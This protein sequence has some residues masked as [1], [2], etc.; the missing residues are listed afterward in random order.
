MLT[1]F[2]YFQKWNEKNQ[3]LIYVKLQKVILKEWF[4]SKDSYKIDIY[5]HFLL[6]NDDKNFD[7]KFHIIIK[8]NIHYIYYNK[9]FD[10]NLLK[11]A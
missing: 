8:L 5:E 9:K 3:I 6:F 10:E 2:F 4:Y 1:R 7:I 11:Q